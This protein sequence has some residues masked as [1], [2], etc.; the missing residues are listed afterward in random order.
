[1][2]E[3]EKVCKIAMT[4]P[5]GIPFTDLVFARIALDYY[6]PFWDL[7]PI[8]PRPTPNVILRTADDWGVWYDQLEL[9]A[10]RS[11]TPRVFG[12]IWIP[13]SNPPRTAMMGLLPRTAA[14][15]RMEL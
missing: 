15:G 1:M 2:E 10:W 14:L 8:N 5:S 7:E 11:F 9:Y 6:D 12:I 4:G 13:I 3:I